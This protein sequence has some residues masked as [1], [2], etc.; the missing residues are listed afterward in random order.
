M[1]SILSILD[2]TDA[3]FKA[4]FCVF[5]SSVAFSPA[6]MNMLYV[7]IESTCGTVIKVEAANCCGA[8]NRQSGTPSPPWAGQSDEL[9]EITR[10]G[11]PF[12]E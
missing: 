3:V 2:F 7:V 11:L 9:T 8:S 6:S 10:E 5:N 1:E 4:W 12:T